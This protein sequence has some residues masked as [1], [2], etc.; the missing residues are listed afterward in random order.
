MGVGKQRGDQ[1]MAGYASVSSLDGEA[2]AWYESLDDETQRDW[3][4]L[5][6]A[7][8]SRYTNLADNQSVPPTR[9]DTQLLVF[10]F[11]GK[12]KEDCRSFVKTVRLRAYSETIQHG[13]S[14]WR[15]L[16]FFG[17]ALDWHASLSADV[18]RD[19][20]RLERAILLDFPAQP[21]VSIAPARIHIEDWY[22]RIQPSAS[23]L[24]LQSHK[25]WLMRA[26]ECRRMYLEA[27]DKSIPCW[28]LVETESEIPDNAIATGPGSSGRR[29]YSARAWLER[30]GLVAGK[31]F[32][33]PFTA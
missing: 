7:L 13:L 16:V 1:W 17:K 23:L 25:D 19:W 14:N 12:D 21:T 8:L 6:G 11:T 26:R 9:V 33:S 2:L 27:N 18:Q 28:L 20:R 3:K 22:H 15:I 24:A 32:R 5:H 4:L 29:I 30:L 10:T 31:S